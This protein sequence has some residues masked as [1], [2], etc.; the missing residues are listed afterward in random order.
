MR[1]LNEENERIKRQ[2]F[3][4]LREADRQSEPSVDKVAAALVR[5]EESTG[6]KSFKDFHIGQ[7]VA[8][9]KELAKAKNAETGKAL[10]KATV[11]ATLRSV[12]AFFK[13]LAWRPG[14]KSRIGRSDCEYFNLS[15]KDG[16]VAHA[17]REKPFPS[18]EQALHAFRQMP[19]ESEIERR[20][21]A[22]LAFLLLTGVRDGAAASLKLK[23]IDLIEGEVIQ[24]A[25]E[26]KTKASKTIYTWFFPV[27]PELRECFERWVRH[28]REARL[29]GPDDPLFPRTAVEVREGRFQPVGLTRLNWSTAATIRK[30]VGGA[31]EAAGL[32]RFGPHSFRKTLVQLGERVCKTPEEFKAWSQNLGH[33]KVLTT[34]TSYGSVSR[35]RQGEIIK[36]LAVA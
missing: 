3:E 14:Y 20:D 7:A 1:K 32:P 27:E 31:F 25:R 24:D 6:Y 5:F 15:A 2:Y 21:R 35:Y 16:A 12:K 11:S 10:S 8:F 36:N 22:V 28:L 26:V 17:H 33:E 13:W 29:F 4:Y 19:G 34:F 9:K 23:H 18:M 30:I